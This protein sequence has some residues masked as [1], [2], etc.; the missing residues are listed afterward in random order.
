MNDE[1]E[2]AVVRA[3]KEHH[4]QKGEQKAR[5]S[6]RKAARRPVKSGDPRGEKKKRQ[7]R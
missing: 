1:R 7:I 2:A 6:G 3:R 4:K 5:T